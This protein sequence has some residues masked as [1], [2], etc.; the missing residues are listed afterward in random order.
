MATEHSAEKDASLVTADHYCLR[1]AS[2]QCDHAHASY[3][4]PLEHVAGSVHAARL[5]LRIEYAIYANAEGVDKTERE[6]IMS[7]I[8]KVLVSERVIASADD[9]NQGES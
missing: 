7:A 5:L 2:Y 1:C 6:C 8:R 9:S 3:D 4:V